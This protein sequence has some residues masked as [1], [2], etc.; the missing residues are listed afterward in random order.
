[1]SGYV[2]GDRSTPGLPWC[3]ELP[4][5]KDRVSHRVTNVDTP[6]RRSGW[7][8]IRPETLRRQPEGCLSGP[9]GRYRAWTLCLD[10]TGITLLSGPRQNY[11]A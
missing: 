11:P 9:R 5:Q 3:V 7:V 1:M 2:Y 8:M 10:D 4:T 6:D